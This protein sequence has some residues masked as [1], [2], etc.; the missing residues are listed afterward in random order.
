[1]PV[2]GERMTD[3]LDTMPLAYRS[4]FGVDETAEHARIVARRGAALA[5]AEL[6]ETRNGSVVCLVTDA[7]PGLL[8]LV[9][10]ALLVHGFGIRCAQAYS[11]VR[12]DGRVEAVDP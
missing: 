9:T 2:A 12:P 4:A 1:M 5:H 8:V 10:D 6:C 3:F 7:R 11:R